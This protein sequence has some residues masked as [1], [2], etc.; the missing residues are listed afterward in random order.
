VG[1]E[2]QSKKHVKKLK[3]CSEEL[4]FLRKHCDSAAG[5]GCVYVKTVVV[6]S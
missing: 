3:A 5:E 6:K 1:R 4:M 2:N